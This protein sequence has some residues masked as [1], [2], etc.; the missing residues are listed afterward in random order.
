HRRPDVD[1]ATGGTA[2]HA[3]GRSHVPVRVGIVQ[4]RRD[5]RRCRCRDRLLAAVAPGQRTGGRAT[6]PVCLAQKD[7]RMTWTAPNVDREFTA[8]NNPERAALHDWLRY[9]RETL[10][11]KCAGLTPEQLRTRS[12]EPSRLTLLGL[13]RHMAEVERFWFRIR[14]GGVD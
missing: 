6:K 10:L 7:V 5:R 3:T 11:M 2:V 9:H 14:F 12:A 8:L 13:V 1:G 4:R